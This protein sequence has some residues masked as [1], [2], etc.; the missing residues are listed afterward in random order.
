MSTDKITTGD[1]VQLARKALYPLYEAGEAHVMVEMLL[2]DI[3]ELDRLGLRMAMQDSLHPEDRQR[4]E[5]LL[6]ALVLGKPIQYVL[7][8]ADFYGLQFKVNE[9]TLIPRQETEELVEKV[10][11]RIGE[12]PLKVLEVG[13]GTGCIAVALKKYA[14]GI[15]IMSIDISQ[16]ALDL[17][18]ANAAMN[19]VEVDF[20][21]CD[22][23]DEANWGKLM[24]ADMVVSNPPY[25]LEAEAAAMENH[26]LGFE[27]H[28]ALFVTDNDPQQFYRKILDWA[29]SHEKT[30]AVFLELNQQFASGTLD[31]YE[32]AGWTSVLYKDL[33][34][35]DR[36]LA[37][38]R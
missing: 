2:C 4:F 12:Q 22:F 31:L 11:A 27:P 13:T 9:H 16:E 3:L 8:Y 23:L 26:V 25:I 30:K 10:L 28:A 29:N 21:L 1:A 6:E 15:E 20:V 36:I 24:D 7:G 32:N 37:A 17:A 33:N 5:A 18:A 14:P 35:N 38:F 34:D 19:G